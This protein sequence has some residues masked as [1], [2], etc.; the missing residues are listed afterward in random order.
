MTAGTYFIYTTQNPKRD[1]L[2]HDSRNHFTQKIKIVR[3][4]NKI[5]RV[6]D[7][8]AVPSAFDMQM[9]SRRLKC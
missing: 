1:R 8:N 2:Q 9:S 5:S 7:L 6:N 4:I 3:T